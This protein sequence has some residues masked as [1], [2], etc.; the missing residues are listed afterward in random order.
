MTSV[1]RVML[2]GVYVDVMDEVSRRRVMDSAWHQLYLLS[3]ARL[4]FDVLVSRLLTP[5]TQ[6]Y[7]SVFTTIH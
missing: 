4:P 1:S 3:A 2:N 7:T 5:F 6:H